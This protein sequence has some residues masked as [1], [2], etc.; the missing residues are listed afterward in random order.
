[1]S[2]HTRVR[3]AS[4][5]A[6]IAVGADP[7]TRDQRLYLAGPAQ[8]LGGLNDAVMTVQLR[9]RVTRI[10]DGLLAAGI[11][12]YSPAHDTGWVTS[13]ALPGDRA[14]SAHRAMVDAGL[15]LAVVG[16]PLSAAV[17]VALGWAS[18]QRKP[19]ILVVDRAR[20]HRALID[21]LEAV[22]PVLP[23]EWDPSWS[24]PALRH[25]LGVALNWAEYQDG[26]LP[27]L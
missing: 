10:R 8:D 17:G 23:V 4:P 24:E 15:V 6:D 7:I 21:T 25:T 11:T 2:Q 14:P 26:F 1:V 3:T 27:T 5:A 22:C 16:T 18:A 13:G 19:I 9:E 20:E 12:V